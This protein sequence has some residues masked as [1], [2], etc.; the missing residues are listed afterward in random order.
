MQLSEQGRHHSSE[1]HGTS[2]PF[3]LEGPRFEES[4]HLN[5]VP[6]SRTVQLS[7][8]GYTREHV[9]SLATGFAQTNAF[10]VLSP[11][12]S[13]VLAA[14]IARLEPLA[15]SSARIPRVLRGASFRSRF[16][17]GL[18]QSAALT[19][20]ASTIAGT[21]LVPH[22][23][24]IMNGHVNL[25]PLDRAKGV[26]RWH[27]DTTPFVLVLF[28]TPPE[29]YE[30]G[31]FE[32]FNGTVAEAE[33]ILSA[34]RALPPERCETAGR[35]H[36]GWAVFQQGSEV[37]HRARAVSRGA[38]I[39][40]VQS[41]VATDALAREACTRLSDT[42]NGVDPLHILIPDWGRYRCWRATRL[43]EHWLAHEAAGRRSDGNSSV[44][45]RIGRRLRDTAET[46]PYTA[47]RRLLSAALAGTVDEL[48]VVAAE[49]EA[50]ASDGS[51]LLAH[52]IC[53]IDGAV[54][55]VTTLRDP[56]M[57]YY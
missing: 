14:E 22:P 49:A 55:D 33:S 7:Q 5:L 9:A 29:E 27:H 6:P 11:E 38:R 23:M 57:S 21:E 39:S 35:Q 31:E 25:S 50:E 18:C 12:G 20:L 45:A 8:L 34:G 1:S 30:G 53:V 52:A 13:R 44:V 46:L 41:Y 15:V 37:Y 19:A 26:D 36:Q 51:A 3:V 47:D 56:T 32:F 10:S 43:V 40:F 17:R 16:V 4:K 2:S 54:S 24:E 48:R 28:A 42:Y